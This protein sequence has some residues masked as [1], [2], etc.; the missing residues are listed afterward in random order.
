MVDN[1]KSAGKSELRYFFLDVLKTL[2]ALIEEKDPFLRKH[3]QRVGNNCANFCERFKI[4]D[5]EDTEKIY[6]AGVLHDIGFITV[7]LEILQ[8]PENMVWIKKH[9]VRG[10]KIL[11]NLSYVK[12]ILP[13]IRHH[14]EAIDGSGYPDGLKK[15]NI[16][17][18]ARVI[19][20]FNHFDNLVFPRPS[21][22]ATSVVE[23]LDE[24]MSNAGNLFDEELIQDFLFY[25]L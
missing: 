8:K 16:P 18:G 14:H 3:S 1:V 17:L 15:D 12:D 4:V 22:Q 25:I 24:I 7:P 11:A 19:A 2:A 23:A 9:P 13:M 21:Q 10:E 20:L 5:E 6:Y